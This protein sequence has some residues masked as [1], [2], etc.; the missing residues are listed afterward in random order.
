M[1]RYCFFLL[2]SLMGMT[3]CAGPKTPVPLIPPATSGTGSDGAD[4]GGLR[5]PS[6]NILPI[7]T[8]DEDEA[9]LTFE[10][11]I[12]LGYVAYTILDEDENVVLTGYV[13]IQQDMQES[14][15]VATLP[16][17][18]YTLEVEINDIT[19]TG[20]FTVEP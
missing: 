14:I 16:A 2:F 12:T 19:Y 10:G 13:N 11:V 6:L 4:H 18:D 9:S 20:S 1:K 15:S 5:S 17:G 7:V 3:L 8:Y